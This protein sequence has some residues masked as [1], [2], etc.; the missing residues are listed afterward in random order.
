MRVPGRRT[1]IALALGCIISAGALLAIPAAARK[2]AA[3]PAPE[4][5]TISAEP[6]L[7]DRDKPQET[8][9]GKL[10]WRGTL[11]LTSPAPNFGGYSGIEV[12]GDGTRLVAVSDAGSWLTAHILYQDG[13]PAGLDDA[14]IGPLVGKNGEPVEDRN[15]DSESLAFAEAG[16]VNGKAYVSFERNHR[17]IAYK[18]EKGVFGAAERSIK[19][20]PRSKEVSSN[21]GIEAITVLRAGPGRGALLAFTEDHLDQAGNHVGWLIGGSAPGALTVKSIGGFAITD[22]TSLPGGD[23]VILER[24]FRLMEGVKMRLRRIRAANIRPG[25]LLEG[26][27]L[28]ETDN[29]REIDNMEGLAAH[30]DSNGVTVLTVISDDNF[31]PTFQRTLLMQFGLPEN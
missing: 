28:L 8:R 17:V 22:T 23:I 26:D 16:A 14:R 1:A 20:P 7:F 10:I 15:A 19:L 29:L 3:L 30:R 5:I 25:A 2:P 6:I 27:V 4:T 18:V 21:G 13:R 12:S 24:R 11:E 31:N 9:F